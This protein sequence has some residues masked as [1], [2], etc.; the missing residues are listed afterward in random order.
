MMSLEG[1]G[2]KRWKRTLRSYPSTSIRW[3]TEGNH[4][5]PQL[6]YTASGPT[7]EPGASNIRYRIANHCIVTFGPLEILLY[8]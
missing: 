6:I 1:R 7:I 5:N 3:K 8:L 4:E 2:K